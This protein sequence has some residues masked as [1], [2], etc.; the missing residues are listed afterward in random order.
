MKTD[1]PTHE[2]GSTNGTISFDL[3]GTLA[4]LNFEKAVWLTEIPRLFAKKNNLDFETAKKAVFSAYE[5]VGDRDAKWYDIKFWFSELGLE[6]DYNSLLEGSSHLIKLYPDTVP[7][8]ERLGKG[9]DLVVI[10]NATRDFIDFKL[11]VDDLEKYF[12]RVFSTTSDFNCIKGD[13][14]G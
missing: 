8:L 1:F 7:A 5:Y 2:R 13:S 4:D 14:K 3:D 10:S 6:G 12:S 11:K 9:Y